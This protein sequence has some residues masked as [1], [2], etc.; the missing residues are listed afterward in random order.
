MGL[1]DIKPTSFARGVPP[2]ERNGFY[3]LEQELIENAQDAQPIVAIV[4]YTLDEVVSKAL[5]G[6][7]YPVVKAFSIE[8]LHDEKSI[9]AAVKLR[10]AAL[11][12]RT[13]V[14][15]LDLPEVVD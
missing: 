11:K 9:A 4:T 12:E 7:T 5:A 13:G 3:G 1:M 14:E 2:E 15:Q 8:P 6:E 10:D